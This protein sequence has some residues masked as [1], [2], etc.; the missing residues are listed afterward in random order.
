[1]ADYYWADE[2]A[3]LAIKLI[4]ENHPHL[5][6]VPIAYTFKAVPPKKKKNDAVQ[7]R[8]KKETWAKTSKVSESSK[9]LMVQRFEFKIEF[10]HAKWIELAE[11]PDKQL[12]LVH[13]EL[14]HCG[15]DA[16]GTYLIPHSIEEMSSTV[17][18]FGL[19]KSDVAQFAA[20]IDHVLHPD[21]EVDWNNPEF[22]SVLGVVQ[23]SKSSPILDAAAGL[24][25]TGNAE[26]D[27][28]IDE[29]AEDDKN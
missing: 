12:A 8:I 18:K 27:K 14:A 4:E 15:N 16:D 9:C 7:G 28:L 2:P 26:I 11:T 1:M 20:T 5:T 25:Y 29:Q 23:P 17:E 3:G 21:A 6:G 10:N 19:W 22:A 13:H 24:P